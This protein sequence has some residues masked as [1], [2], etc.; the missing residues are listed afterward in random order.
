MAASSAPVA[1]QT[2]STEKPPPP[3]LGP[4]QNRAVADPVSVTPPGAS[5]KDSHSA[6]RAKPQTPPPALPSPAPFANCPAQNRESHS[7]AGIAPQSSPDAHSHP[8]LP[9]ASP[10]KAGQQES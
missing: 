3:H 6:H 4:A 10:E 1:A 7:T 9:A 2:P 8:P 5:T